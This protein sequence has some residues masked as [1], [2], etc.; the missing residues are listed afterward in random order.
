LNRQIFF[1]KVRFVLV[2]IMAYVPNFQYDIFISYS[3]V[4]NLPGPG[5]TEG[6]V[7]QFE[8][9]LKNYL[10]RRIGRMGVIEIWRDPAIDGSE[11]FDQVIQDKINQSAV[12]VALSSHG[13]FLSD[14]CKKE[15]KSF[16][17]RAKQDSTGISIR[18]HLR[19]LN[20]RIN[21]IQ[22]DQW[23]EEYGRTTGYPFFET[24]SDHELG[25]PLKP[26]GERFEQQ[27][28]KLVE[29]AYKTLTALKERVAPEPE[30]A[31]P[32]NT[33]FLADTADSLSRY[34]RRIS[35]E[36]R[37]AGVRVLDSIPPPYEAKAHEEKVIQE[38]RQ[39]DL[40]VHLLDELSGK[41][42][43]GDVETSY[44]QKQVEL[45]LKHAQSQLI[46]IPQTLD[47]QS[48]EDEVQRILLDQVENG[49]RGNASYCFIRGT[50]SS[51]SREILEKLNQDRA[52]QQKGPVP[53]PSAALVDTHLK[54]QLHAFK[55]GEFLI[56]MKVQPYINPEEDNPQLNMKI[57]EE[58]LKQVS[59]LI[60]IFGDV[61]EDWVRA[62]LGIAVQIAV[63][64][65][66]PLKACGVYFAPPRQR[67]VDGMFALP[68]LPV[69]EFD[70][71]DISNPD[72]LK[73][74][75]N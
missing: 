9:Y 38:I 49:N 5:E 36:L 74:M 4:D 11:L 25:Y 39:A 57:L 19:I 10:S 26:T 72:T 12:L 42:I 44:P 18:D 24:E 37:D 34:R 14:Y 46:W 55:L 51:I 13:Y 3:H 20:V 33:V 23:P 32:T 53:S 60:I 71:R 17:D 21:N 41:E 69:Y 2:R 27:L 40:S 48:V 22:R 66:C 58:R 63:T 8:R 6:W 56:E 65:R 47:V 54:D 61:A 73:Q 7:T 52:R 75:L 45:G 1:H 15:L 70:S 68:F 35:N 43:Q 59:K 30:P 31:K 16:W 29:G 67:G 50:A 28:R 64:E 62:R